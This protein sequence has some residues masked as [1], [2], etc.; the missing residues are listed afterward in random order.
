VAVLCSRTLSIVFTTNNKKKTDYKHDATLKRTGQGNV[1]AT[2][3]RTQYDSAW[4]KAH[5]LLSDD[6]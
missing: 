1:K 5:G 3:T 2:F 6:Q 4:H